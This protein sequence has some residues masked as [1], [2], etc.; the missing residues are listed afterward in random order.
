MIVCGKTVLASTVISHL[1]STEDFVNNL[2]LFYFFELTGPTTDL[3]EF[4]FSLIAQQCSSS[5]ASR[6]LLNE[7]MSKT[8][9][10][11]LT[12]DFLT[13]CFVEVALS[14]KKQFLVIDSFENCDWS[15]ALLEW[16]YALAPVK[17]AKTN[18]FI[19]SR[20]RSEYYHL[21]AWID[22][23]DCL[24]L[25]P[26]LVQDDINIY[27]RSALSNYVDRATNDLERFG[28]LLME[29]ANGM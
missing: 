2:S 9:A 26:D 11:K 13:R 23:V 28:S 24:Y 21:R 29:H 25:R 4:V 8:T 16:I 15:E 1:R 6:Q 19:T 20:R 3:R 18:L 12:V 10:S 27:V 7:L 5:E 22:R 17:A 14:V